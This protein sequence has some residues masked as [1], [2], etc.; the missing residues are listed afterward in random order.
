MLLEQCTVSRKT[1]LDGKLEVAPGTAERLALFGNA[2]PIV[3]AEQV[4]TAQ[5]TTLECT[6]TKGAGER[7]VHHFIES[8]MLR[9]LE[10]GAVVGVALD[11]ERRGVSV[12]AV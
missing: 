8:P 9:E 10:P 11:E 2:F 12:V 3:S 1:P 5:L 7:H 4:G 6:C